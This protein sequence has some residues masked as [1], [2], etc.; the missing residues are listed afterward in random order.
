[1]LETPNRHAELSNL[2]HQEKHPVDTKESAFSAAKAFP[3]VN[4]AICALAP[5]LY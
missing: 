4:R 2:I 3:N 5:T 1:M